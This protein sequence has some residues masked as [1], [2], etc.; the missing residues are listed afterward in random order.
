MKRVRNQEEEK[1]LI[2]VP[3]S[4]VEEHNYIYIPQYQDERIGLQINR[5]EIPEFIDQIV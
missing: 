2:Q 3:G 4:E 1:T 5:A